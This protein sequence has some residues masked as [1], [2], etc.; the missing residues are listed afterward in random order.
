MI[1]TEA[2]RTTLK[3]A[4]ERYKREVTPGKKGA[5]REGRRVTAWMNNP[6]ALRFLTTLRGGD[7]AEYRDERLAEG[8]A[9]NTVRMELS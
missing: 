9:W 2:A 1:S 6:L 7:F 5:D 3:E 4:L 8:K